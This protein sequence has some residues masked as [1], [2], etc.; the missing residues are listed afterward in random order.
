MGLAP[1]HLLYPF[2]FIPFDAI[3]DNRKGC[4]CVNLPSNADRKT[5]CRAFVPMYEEFKG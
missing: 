1:I 5:A 3:T 4:P 2:A